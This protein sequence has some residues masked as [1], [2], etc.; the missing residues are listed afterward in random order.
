MK[1]RKSPRPSEDLFP[2]KLYEMLEY[3][4]RMDLCKAVTWLPHGRAF[5]VGD[6]EVFMAELVPR[7][8]KSTK[9]RSFY[10]QLHLWGFNRITSG[11][12]IGAWWH[13]SF[14]CGRPQDLKH[15]VRRIQVKGKAKIVVDVP[16]SDFYKI[17]PTF[18]TDDD[19]RIPNIAE[20]SLFE[21]GCSVEKAED[22]LSASACSGF[23]A[24]GVFEHLARMNSPRRTSMISLPIPSEA[25]HPFSEGV[26]P[27]FA[28]LNYN[29]SNIGLP[30]GIGISRSNMDPKTSFNEP[31]AVWSSN[32]SIPTSL[33]YQNPVHMGC[34][35]D[36]G[37]SGQD[38]DA[39]D[40]FSI[41]IDKNIHF[42]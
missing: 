16:V 35:R 19:A 28:N 38:I 34:G 40:E 24:A 6:K 2:A 13:E 26:A 18:K 25:K 17:L 10:R 12:D 11:R 20:I 21:A 39:L 3:V 15:M 36:H 37:T 30:E 33:S 1:K 5:L 8:F 23:D 14:V 27:F 31:P 7:F 32:S 29:T 9:I 41:F 22:M 42:L 4:Q